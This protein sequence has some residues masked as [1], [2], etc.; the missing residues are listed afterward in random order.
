[1]A[2]TNE[3]LYL[4]VWVV[5]GSILG[6]YSFSRSYGRTRRDKFIRCLLSIGIGIF[7][8]LPIYTYLT[9]I[10]KYSAPLNIMISG[11]GAFGLPDF[12][13]KHWSTLTDALAEKAVDQLTDADKKPKHKYNN[14]YFD[15]GDGDD[16]REE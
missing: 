13:L 5:T 16:G 14:N 4:L 11:I 6:F 9:E 10:H 8:A 7:L 15:I 3:V 2:V 1:M 12:I